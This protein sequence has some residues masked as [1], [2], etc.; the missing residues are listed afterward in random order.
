MSERLHDVIVVGGGPAGACTAYELASLGH[1]VVVLEQKHTPGLNSCCTGIV[2]TGCFDLLDPGEDVVLAR[3]SS[4]SFFSPSGRRLRLETGNARAYVVD[5]SLLD[6]ALAARARSAG[7]RYF[8]STRAVDIITGSDSMSVEATRSG[9]TEVFDARAVVL[10]SGFKPGLSRKLG[11]GGPRSFLVGA[12]AEVEARDIEE[13]E[14]HLD[15]RFNRGSFAW[16][17]PAGGHRAYAGL[18]ATSRAGPQLRGFLSDLVRG[19]RITSPDV[20]I[21]QKPV[22]IGGADRTYGQRVLVVGDA[23]GQVKATTGGGIYFGH[24]AARIAAAVLDQALRSDDLS[25]ERLAEYQTRWKAEMGKELS[26]GYRARRIW[27]RLS[28][29]QIDRIFRLMDSTGMIGDL[30]SADGFSFDRHTQALLAVLRHAPLYPFIK[31]KQ[32]LANRVR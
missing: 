3:A 12:Q 18:L 7:A 28:H 20:E 5:R 19:G 23:A 11:L 32:L 8:L 15:Q 21:R 24:L 31:A 9:V 14:V 2:S 16:L 25:A 29:S 27:A 13:I 10:A 22:P 30:V 4:A 26:N 6:K 17:V 1:D